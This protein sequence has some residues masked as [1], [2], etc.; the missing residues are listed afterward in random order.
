MCDVMIDLETMGTQ[1]G[2]AIIALGAVTFDLSGVKEVFYTN[3]S[4]KSCMSEGLTVDADTVLW[5]MQQSD[6]A[7]KALIDNP[8]PLRQALALFADWYKSVGGLYLWGNGSDFDNILLG[9]AY[10][11][12]DIKQPW[13]YSKNRCYRTVKNMYENI[14]MDR[15]GTHHNAL[16]DATSQAEH[17]VKIFNHIAV[18]S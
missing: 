9:Q 7:R 16:D 17:L 18:S 2:S 3:I 14:E 10:K 1:P 15:K 8:R 6:D 11:L 13:S 12:C 5:W 4:L